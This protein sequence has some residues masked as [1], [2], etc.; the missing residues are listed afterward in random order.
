[1]GG[2]RLTEDFSSLEHADLDRTTGLWNVVAGQARAAV[3]ANAEAGRPILFGNG[4]D[5]ALDVSGA[6]TFN[7]D[8][9]TDGIFN[10]TSVN[11]RAGATITVTGSNPLRIRS[12]GAVTIDPAF[13]ARSSSP[14]GDPGNAAGTASTAGTAVTCGALG[15]RAG[16]GGHIAAN[17][18][19]NGT[20]GRDSAGNPEAGLAGTGETGANTA[21]V[22]AQGALSSP[23]SANFDT[24]ANFQCGTGGAGGGGYFLGALQLASGGAGGAGGGRLHITAVG[25]L[26]LTAAPNASGGNGGNGVLVA[27]APNRCS[28]NAAGGTGGSV[29]L[30]TLGSLG[31]P[32]PNVDG[33]TGGTSVCDGVGTGQGL[34]GI[35]RGDS[36]P[37]SRPGFVGASDYDTDRV[38]ANT[39]SVVYSKAYDLSVWNAGFSSA[40]TVTQTLNGG[41]ISVAFAG[42]ADGATFG[43]YSTDLPSLGNRGYRYLKFRITITSAGAA[44]ASPFVSRITLSYSDLGLEALKL[45]L[46]PG[47]GRIG[48]AGPG[49]PPPADLCLLAGLMLLASLA[50]RLRGGAHGPR[51]G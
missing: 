3:Y 46:T 34:S 43:D 28:G 48:R 42:S 37:G 40:P 13:P 45:K 9:R 36:A 24:A 5:G 35:S 19:Q 33:G 49:G 18:G 1:M 22:N 25:D 23:A 30:Q 50:L 21:A 15:A 16:A 17:A 32:Q 8:S 10:F 41:T 29:W 44:A 11:I 38:P 47:C 7:T 6:Y 26:N 39:T 31:S 20:E 27:A 14:S 4:S 51:G 12:L 2:G